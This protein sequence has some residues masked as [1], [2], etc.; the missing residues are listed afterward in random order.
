MVQGLFH[1]HGPGHQHT[2]I[3]VTPIGVT[4]VVGSVS[5]AAAAPLIARV[6]ICAILKKLQIST[7]FS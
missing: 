6:A 4:A 5:G 1:K 7:I 2:P 3:G